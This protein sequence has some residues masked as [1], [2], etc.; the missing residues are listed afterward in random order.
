MPR[1][2]ETIETALHPAPLATN[3][4]VLVV[5]GGGAGLAAAV[6]AAQL[7]ARV[8]LVERAAQLGGT[9]AKA[10]GSISAANSNA[11]RRAGITDSLESNRDDMKK[12]IAST[13]DR[14]I[15]ELR[16]MLVQ[17][18]GPTVDWLESIGV[19][20]IGPF[21]EPP[22]TVPRLHN[23]FPTSRAYIDHLHRK[24][25]K[26]GVSI[27]TGTRLI[28][29]RPSAN[30]WMTELEGRGEAFELNAPTIILAAGDMSGNDALRRKWL[31]EAAVLALPINRQNTGDAQRL[32]AANGAAIR[33]MD[34]IYGPQL[35]FPAA[36]GFQLITLLPSWPWFQK[37]AA[38]C[39]NV[40]PMWLMRPFVRPM[41]ITN[42]SPSSVLF[43]E[44]AILINRDGRRFCD[45]TV[46]VQPLS[47]QPDACGYIVLSRAVAQK[48]GS[49]GNYLSTIPGLTYAYLD[50]YRK[51]RPDLFHEATDAAALASKLGM[52]PACLSASAQDAWGPDPGRLIALGPVYSMLTVTEGGLAIDTSCRVLDDAGA[53]IPGLYAAGG[54]GGGLPLNGHGHHIAW[55]MASGRIA[56]AT[57]ART[58]INTGNGRTKN[59]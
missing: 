8:T 19:A 9:T 5:G 4:D 16:E 10:V 57:A 46:S 35:R 48:F 11:Q 1:L 7:G 33:N 15:P 22:H 50:D 13:L 25:V 42:L 58:A 45:E 3:F 20:F 41:M 36:T 29:L 2:P 28:G 52:D 24:A 12:F 18:A 59:Q 51:G 17:E 37:L 44:G 23:A 21:L 30:G 53:P 6:S 34:L 14:D 38:F 26:L 43:A 56:G 31:P 49:K 39:F 55:A 47:S 32:G 27:M 54:S 40:A